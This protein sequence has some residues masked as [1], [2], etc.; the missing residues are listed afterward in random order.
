MLKKIKN[1][2]FPNFPEGEFHYSTEGFELA[3]RWAKRQPHPRM[4][5]HP[6]LTLWDHVKSN[7]MESEHKLHEINKMKRLKDQSK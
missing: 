7:W 2:L 1:W 3:K 4:P 6:R 5:D